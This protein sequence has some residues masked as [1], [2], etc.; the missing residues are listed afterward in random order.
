[1][2]F[3]RESLRVFFLFCLLLAF[4]GYASDDSNGS[5]AEAKSGDKESPWLLT[6]LL[7]SGPKMGTSLGAMAGYLYRFDE[8]SPTSTFAVMGTYSSTDSFVSGLFTRTFFDA[9]T[10]RLVA[11]VLYGR[12]NNEYNDFLGSGFPVRTTD[13]LHAAFVRYSYRVFSQWY[14]GGQFIATDYAIVGND[15]FSEAVLGF[16]GLDGFKSNGIG[17]N[18]EFDSRDNVNSPQKGT[19]F[20]LSNVA[21][22]VG[23]GGDANFDVYDFKARHYL[24]QTPKLVLA[25]RLDGKWTNDAPPGAYATVNLRGYTQGQYLAPNSNVAEIEERLDIAHGI[26]ATLFGGVSCLYDH[27]GD[28]GTKSNLFPSVGGGFNYMLKKEEKMVVRLEGAMGKDENY[29]IYMQFGRGF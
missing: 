2:L 29:G 13:D 3:E 11:G 4:V 6:P 22:R 24:E 7:S 9:N 8:A 17:L 20:N 25:M 27:L 14:F 28:C 15:P 21:Y 10:Q 5:V 16:I 1:M 26:G 12:I 19:F 18:A 23:L